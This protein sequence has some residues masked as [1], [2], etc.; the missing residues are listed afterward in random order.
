MI[1]LVTDLEPNLWY[2]VWVK[3]AS[4]AYKIFS[5]ISVKFCHFV[6]S[7]YPYI[8]ANFERF[9]F[10]FS[11]MALICLQVLIVFTISSFEFHQD[12]LLLLHRQG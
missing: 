1:D 3:K 2:T 10:V 11:N 9:I 6:A 4:T 8:F 5:S 7:S 12:K